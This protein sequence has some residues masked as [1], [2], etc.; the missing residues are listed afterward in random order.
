MSYDD[1]FGI[2]LSFLNVLVH[3]N[4]QICLDWFQEGEGRSVYTAV[5]ISDSVMRSNDFYNSSQ[6]YG[7]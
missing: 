4:L 3:L 6:N 1:T 7:N 5:M 2:P